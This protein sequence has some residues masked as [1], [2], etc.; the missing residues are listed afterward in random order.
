VPNARIAGPERS[1]TPG[2]AQGQRSTPSTGRDAQDPNSSNMPDAAE[3]P[4]TAA[5]PQK[6]EAIYIPETPQERDARMRRE[7]ADSVCDQYG[8]QREACRAQAARH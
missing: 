5:P 2:T 6:P 7:V 3:D 4:D 1:T 8:V